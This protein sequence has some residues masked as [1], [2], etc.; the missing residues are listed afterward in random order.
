MRIGAVQNSIAADTTAPVSVQRTALHSKISR[1][2]EAAA[3]CGVNVLCYQEAW[4]EYLDLG[5]CHDHD[6]LIIWPY[7]GLVIKVKIFNVMLTFL[8]YYIHR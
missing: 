6:L 8:N 1:I 3:L 7:T 5:M 4:S 2:T